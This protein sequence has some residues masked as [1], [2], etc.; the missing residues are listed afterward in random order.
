MVISRK[1][2]QEIAIQLMEWHGGQTTALYSLASSLIARDY[3]VMTRDLIDR[4]KCELWNND[5][6][7]T[8]M[9]AE[10]LESFYL[11]CF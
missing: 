9:L 10:S 6:E 3:K 5:A 7:E 2:A 1:A 4:A 11:S 8:D